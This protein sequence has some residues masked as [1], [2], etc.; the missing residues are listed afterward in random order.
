LQD[1]D[2]R[3]TG[4]ERAFKDTLPPLI[5]SVRSLSDLVERLKREA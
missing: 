5:E 1:V 2:N 3:L 4:L